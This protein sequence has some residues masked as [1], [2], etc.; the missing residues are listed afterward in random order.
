MTLTKRGVTLKVI[1]RNGTTAEWQDD[2]VSSAVYK[3]ASRSNSKD[4]GLP[5]QVEAL[6]KQSLLLL[7]S[8]QVEID[9]IHK[10]VENTLMDLKAY[11]V[12][13]EYITYRKQHMPDIYRPRVAYRPYE[14]PQLAKYVEAIQH[15]YWIFTHYNYNSDVQDIKINMPP[16]QAETAL[17]CILAI[18][19][20]EVAVKRFWANIGLMFPKPELEEVAAVFSD[21]EV[22]HSQAYANLLNLMHLNDRFATLQEVH[23]I[24]NRIKFLQ[25]SIKSASTKEEQFKS[26]ILF[27]MFI[28]NVS[29]FSQFYILLKMNKEDKYL[30]GTANAIFSTS[31]EE[32]LHASFGFD[33]V[34]TIKQENPSWWTEGLKQELVQEALQAL[35]V[36][37]DVLSWI[38]NGDSELE[39]E[40]SNFIILRMAESLSA[41]GITGTQLPVTNKAPYEWFYTL[42]E[43]RMA[44]DFF[45]S[46]DPAY[47]KGANS[48]TADD[49]F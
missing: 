24:N 45:D 14:Y 26:V 16:Q 7:E 15:S 11:D 1:K 32:V 31:K 49:L 29:L 42:T 38:C 19:Q 30:K 3:A 36:E 13:R 18:S 4:V 20:I 33:L 39:A 8:E 21:S 9:V 6:V 43:S 35:E 10:L 37:K 28:E 12:A 34:N 23:A 25:K 2:K 47:T 48:I 5:L 17:R 44:V 40:V 46:K 22:R 41:I 27:S